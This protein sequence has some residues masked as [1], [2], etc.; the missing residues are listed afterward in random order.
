MYQFEGW[1]VNMV[2]PQVALDFSVAENQKQYSACI[3]PAISE[4]TVENFNRLKGADSMK[5]FP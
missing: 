5:N 3:S 2:W 4:L 1:P